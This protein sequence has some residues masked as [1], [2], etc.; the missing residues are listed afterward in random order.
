MEASKLLVGIRYSVDAFLIRVFE[1]S[2]REIF[3]YTIFDHLLRV[4][5]FS[6]FSIDYLDA[7]NHKTHQ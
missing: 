2:F 3:G 5:Q 7:K 6:R 4:S 1:V